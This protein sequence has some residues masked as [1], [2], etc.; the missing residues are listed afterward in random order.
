MISFLRK[1]LNSWA[2]LGILGLVL[3]A[4]VL[5]GVR[6]PLA[7]RGGDQTVASVGG[8]K[9]GASELQ[10]EITNRVHQI[11]KQQPELTVAMAAQQGG[12]N[13][14]REAM[15]QRLSLDEIMRKFG[16]KAGTNAVSEMV[17]AEPAFQVAGKFDSKTYE[18]I[19]RTNRL[20]PQKY[21]NQIA[22]ALA[23]Q[24]VTAA[25][26]RGWKLPDSVLV[27]FASMLQQ[28]RVGTLAQ[29]TLAQAGPPPPVNEAQLKAFYLKN[30]GRY[31]S[32][33]LR[34]FRYFTLDLSTVAAT[35]IITDADIQK[36]YT[37]HAVDFGGVEERSLE[38]ATLESKVD[39]DTL[40]AKV[41]AGAAFAATAKASVAGL[42]D[43][44]I[45]RGMTTEKDLAKDIKP[46]MAK[47]VFSLPSGGISQPIETELGFQVFHVVSIKA[48]KAAALDANARAV[49]TEHLKKDKSIDKLTD[50]S[51]QIDDAAVARK[52]FEALANMAGSKPQTTVPLSRNGGTAAGVADSNA[53]TLQP[54]LKLAFDQ[55]TGDPLSLQT[56][57]ENHYAVIDVLSVIKSAPRPLES[58]KPIVVAQWQQ[59]QQIAKAK[60]AGD[61]F[62][63]QLKTSKSSFTDIAKTHGYTARSDI[64]LRW[65][66]AE[67][68]DAK[69][70]A[71]LLKLFTLKKGESTV[72]PSPDGNGVVVVKLDDI[73]NQPADKNNPLFQNLKSQVDR[74]GGTEAQSQI[75]IAA[76]N[77]IGVKRNREVI[78]ALHNQLLGNSN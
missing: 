3:A 65:L 38:Q 13:D 42:T 4:F 78:K 10:A 5:T 53:A 8:A 7:G 40:I 34:T 35:I 76:R 6:D 68:P 73:I 20:T 55:R 54:L 49:I 9:L 48:A 32:P 31:S 29:I 2:V 74:M 60:I 61:A 23:S 45:A 33:E 56:I 25:V 12:D 1:I 63:A 52:S 59:E 19:L 27:N 69:I 72:I 30:S 21:E 44:D 37:E 36:Y 67:R 50:L 57:D 16:I 51:K 17:A 71:P 11:Q 58:I 77:D 26:G 46:E 64:K 47:A 14:I 15:I 18:D 43:V 70:P 66:D 41:S 28:Q 62:L 75:L 22:S 39:A 24:Q